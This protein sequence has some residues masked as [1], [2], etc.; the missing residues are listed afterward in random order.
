[1]FKL[2]RQFGISV[3]AELSA[4]LEAGGGVVSECKRGSGHSSSLWSLAWL[5]MKAKPTNLQERKQD[6]D[7][8]VYS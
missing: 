5:M 8:T 1:M 2:L 3:G 7:P 6:I 4:T